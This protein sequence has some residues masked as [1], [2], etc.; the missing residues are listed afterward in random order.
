MLKTKV[1][2]F[3]AQMGLA[4]VDDKAEI[5]SEIKR[6][7]DNVVN[8]NHQ[9][10]DSVLADTKKLLDTAQNLDIRTQTESQ[11]QKVQMDKLV[12]T[13]KDIQ[14]KYEA[15]SRDI[16]DCSGDIKQHVDGQEQRI[17]SGTQNILNEVRAMDEKIKTD[18]QQQKVQMDEMAA[19]CRHMQGQYANLAANIK[20]LDE[21]IRKQQNSQNKSS[22]ANQR[23]LR[24][25]EQINHHLAKFEKNSLKPEDLE[26]IVALLRLLIAGQLVTEVEASLKDTDSVAAAK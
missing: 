11:Q 25:L 19:T 20:G 23:I 1:K 4:T 15:V 13:C 8:L 12:E 6:L 17:L 26:N 14:E 21:R 5:V 24:Q 9:L 10:L 2:S 22:E 16:R 3:F 7:N 18:S